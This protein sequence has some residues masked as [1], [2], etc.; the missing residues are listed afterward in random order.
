[1]REEVQTMMVPRSAVRRGV[2]PAANRPFGTRVVMGA[3]VGLSLAVVTGLFAGILILIGG[4]QG[5][6]EKYG[7]LSVAALM[8]TYL[9]LGL[10]GGVLWGVML[11]LT[12]SNV[13]TAFV[14]VIIGVVAA[15]G[16]GVAVDGVSFWF[17]WGVVQVGEV[18][19]FGI[20]GAITAFGMRR[21]MAQ[22]R[23]RQS[24]AGHGDN[25]RE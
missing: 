23:A 10:V 22:I 14:G 25:P 12:R 4:M 24:H 15:V 3:K 20:V 18:V 19:V 7:T 8:A 13:G 16:F 2:V 21:R 11:P 5:F 17:V 1:M 9:S 6:R